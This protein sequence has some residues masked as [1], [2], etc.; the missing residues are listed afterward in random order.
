MPLL[1][2]GEALLIS[3]PKIRFA[4]SMKVKYHPEYLE[5]RRKEDYGLPESRKLP[6]MERRLKALNAQERTA[7]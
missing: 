7:L 6:D 3:K 5:N 4:V 1:D 2:I